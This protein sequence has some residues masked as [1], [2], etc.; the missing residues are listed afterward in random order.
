MNSY[1]QDWLNVIENMS[2]DN[3][4]KLA[5][6]RAII[7]TACLIDN[8][9]D[10]NII[11]FKTIAHKMIKYYWNQ[12]FFFNLNQSANNNKPPILV[13]QVQLLINKYI[14]LSS[15]TIPVW[16][17]KAEYILEGDSAFYNKVLSKCAKTLTENVSWR[18]M[19]INKQ[20]LPLYILDKD[21]LTITLTKEQIILIKEYSFVL[22]QLL[23]YKWA[24]LLESYN[25]SP[26]IASKVKG[27][28]DNTIKRNNL[29]KYK[30]VLLQYTNYTPIDFYTGEV[31]DEND[32]SLDHV[33]PWSF[34]YSDDIWNLVITSKSN[35]SSKSN[36]VPTQE[37]I[38][39]LKQR[40]QSLL[41]TI[42][43]SKYKQQL[44]I[45]ISNDYVD[46]F[47]I[48]MKM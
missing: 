45:A 42:T 15:S 41:Q 1:I 44:E 4:Y 22:S 47:Y 12:T 6:G 40:N 19:I 5:W 11:T 9:E 27:I 13:Q 37:I 38:D 7:E 39:K 46:K 3:T 24:Q 35:N 2:N 30:N 34:M 28:S 26:K 29:T 8:V 10:N 48:A 31:L 20:T 18:F 17:D 43:D 23:N 16:F 33:I 21:N 32:I 25:H 14:E 36:S